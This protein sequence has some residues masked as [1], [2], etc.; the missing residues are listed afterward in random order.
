MDS[1]EAPSTFSWAASL[2]KS[3]IPTQTS[4]ANAKNALV[5]AKI[6]K[7]AIHS[8]CILDFAQYLEMAGQEGA[9]TLHADC[10]VC[11]RTLDIS[12]C[13]GEMVETECALAGNEKAAKTEQE[14]YE[15]HGLEG[16]VVM[17][18]G[19]LIGRD[20]LQKAWEAYLAADDDDSDAVRPDRCFQCQAKATC[21]G[22]DDV[23]LADTK[24]RPFAESTAWPLD[25][26]EWGAAQVYQPRQALQ[27]VTLTAAEKDPGAR[28][29]CQRCTY[30]QIL[31]KFSECALTFPPC[32]KRDPSRHCQQWLRRRVREVTQLICPV[33][34]DVRSPDAAAWYDKFLA[35]GR[36]RVAAD[37]LGAGAMADCLGPE[38]FRAR[39]HGAV[40]CPCMANAEK[41]SSSRARGFR[42]KQKRRLRDTRAAFD[43]ARLFAEMFLQIGKDMPL[44]WYRGGEEI[45]GG[46]DGFRLLPPSSAEDPEQPEQLRHQ[47]FLKIVGGDSLAGALARINP[48][49]VQGPEFIAL[50]ASYDNW[51]FLGM[52]KEDGDDEDSHHHGANAGKPEGEE[53]PVHAQ[54]VARRNEEMWELLWGDV[55]SP[56]GK[57][58][59]EEAWEHYWDDV[60][61]GEF[62]EWYDAWGM[63][64]C[65]Y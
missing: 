38:P 2:L 11:R 8:R 30:Y 40:F 60:W 52:E 47:K 15:K 44:A 62:M 24:F 14:F 39:L 5:L 54:E 37:C 64:D 28:R 56:G 1:L 20:C 9:P 58:A 18:C 57:D 55:V 16:T 45:S 51:E 26:G 35:R 19:H 3:W 23:L 21:D 4:W 10:V 7:G 46:G 63:C 25:D 48:S 53:D 17:R 6:P 43:M 12:S 42:H 32:D 34:A 61:W 59:W 49:V 29:Y 27:R 50:V 65:C 41:L 13:V 31:R 22:C 33:T 36:E